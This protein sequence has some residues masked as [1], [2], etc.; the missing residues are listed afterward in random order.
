MIPPLQPPPTAP[1][2]PIP[3]AGPPTSTGQTSLILQKSRPRGA[4]LPAN[5]QPPK[6]P[7]EAAFT[8][9]ST[10][11]D[12][13]A[14]SP[15]SPPTPATPHTIQLNAAPLPAKHSKSSGRPLTAPGPSAPPPPARVRTTSGAT[16]P[17]RS[18]SSTALNTSASHSNLDG[19]L[20]T[21]VTPKQALFS[22]STL[23]TNPAPKRSDLIPLRN[24][25]AK[26]EIPPFVTIFGLEP[27]TNI[28]APAP[29][30]KPTDPHRHPYHLLRLVLGT[31][32]PP[33]SP[34]RTGSQP[35]GGFITPKLYVPSSLWHQTELWTLVLDLPEKVRLLETLRE[36]LRTVHESSVILFGPVV[37]SSLRAPAKL[38]K[39]PSTE[40]SLPT[41]QPLSKLDDPV[42]WLQALE[43]LASALGD[44]EKSSSKK[45][46]LGENGA[47]VKK[48]MMDWSTRVAKKAVGGKGPSSELM[49]AYVDALTGIC[50]FGPMLDAHFCA[51]K[52]LVPTPRAG[53]VRRPT[54]SRTNTSEALNS[55]Q[56]LSPQTQIPGGGAIPDFLTDPDVL[57]PAITQLVP[58]YSALPKYVNVQA[59]ACL[60]RTTRVFSCFIL[61]LI[62]RDLAVLIEGLQQMRNGEW[63]GIQL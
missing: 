60:E 61:P 39:S 23:S 47:S 16:P 42:E 24:P 18:H 14:K 52:T 51:L 20:S 55:K 30:P 37:F 4:S 5:Q 50:N 48:R 15:R 21:P 6:I 59:A 43:R 10:K 35:T 62:L 38:K 12:L 32:T 17:K 19:R 36:T 58:K 45:L 41:R 44:L 9:A 31:L 8:E 54:I 40:N 26:L 34:S 3:Y 56:P 11:P 28:T 25:Q 63:M 2:P 49:D 1:L 13:D 22:P 46:G 33:A 53:P 27:V 57:P 29:P 7:H